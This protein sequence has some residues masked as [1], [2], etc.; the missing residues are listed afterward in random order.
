[1]WTYNYTNEL[2]HH[3]VKGMRWGVRHKRELIGRRHRRTQEHDENGNKTKKALKVGLIVAGGL[4]AAYGGYKFVDSGSMH[5]LIT[6]GQN[7]LSKQTMFKHNMELANKNF[8]EDEILSKVVS[9]IN[10]DYGQPGTTMNCKRCT[11]AYEMSRRG[12]DVKATKTLKGT[13]QTS[14][15]TY[16]A[17]NEGEHMS[18]LRD[19]L[20]NNSRYSTITVS[21]KPSHRAATKYIENHEYDKNFLKFE[22]SIKK[23]FDSYGIDYMGKTVIKKSDSYSKDIFKQL[24]KH[25]NGARGEIAVGWKINDKDAGGHSM[26]WEIVNNHPVIFDCQNGKKYNY[27]TFS[28]TFDGVLGKASVIR[29]DNRTLNKDFLVRWVTNA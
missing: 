22:K 8:S 12:Y 20:Q 13:G 5:R 25:P 27:A 23:R 19:I 26:A 28:N 16:N 29:L 3:G 18:L 9:R 24:A 2:Y 6:K 7:A 14:Y 11:Y 17:V 21:N 4:L 1:M 15:G 10:P